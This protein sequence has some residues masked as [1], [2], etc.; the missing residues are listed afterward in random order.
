MRTKNNPQ[1]AS[2][3][4][5]YSADILDDV[6]EMDATGGARTVT[7]PSASFQNGNSFTVVKKDSS[8]NTVTISAA[9][10]TTIN[11]A[12]NFTLTKKNQFIELQADGTSNYRITGQSS[13]SGGSGTSAATVLT[14]GA[15]VSLD[16]TLD[17][18]FSLV[19]AQDETINAASVG[20]FGA[21]IYLYI[22][23]SGVTSRNLT[24]GT[25]FKSTGVLAT[26]TTTAKQFLMKFRSDGVNWL[27]Q[28]RTA[29]M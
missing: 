13:Q 17:E 11:G 1:T 8:T 20:P 6:I 16:P 4:A 29:A 25:N 9:G 27:E 2:K 10:G 14:P 26:G 22:T 23:T 28:S 3:S 24:F 19:P 12:A 5:N 7:L 21:D 18:N 15:V